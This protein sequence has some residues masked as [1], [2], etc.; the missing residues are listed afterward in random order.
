MITFLYTLEYPQNLTSMTQ[1]LDILLM[2]DKFSIPTLLDMAFEEIAEALDASEDFEELKA[3]FAATY[4]DAAL[5]L[6][7]LREP[8]VKTCVGRMNRPG[9]RKT[10]DVFL[11]E[12]GEYSS[13]FVRVAFDFVL[14]LMSYIR[15]D[16]NWRPSDIDRACDAGDWV[17]EEEAIAPVP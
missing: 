3:L 10:H 2:A 11:R 8:L 9:F 4:E 6:Q 12:S 14:N 13:D 17:G 16:V 7:R 5:A 1:H 15:E